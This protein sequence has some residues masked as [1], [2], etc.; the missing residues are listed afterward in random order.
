MCH[1]F[2]GVI[3]TF[4]KIC[5]KGLRM[6]TSL[7]FIVLLFVV[8]VMV[9]LLRLKNFLQTNFAIQEIITDLL[10]GFLSD[11]FLIIFICIIL[12]LV[13]FIVAGIFLLIKTAT[14]QKVK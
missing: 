3:D 1:E 7:F 11:I 12:L 13:F 4:N 14:S 2:A 6:F 9:S 10:Q 8:A 5:S